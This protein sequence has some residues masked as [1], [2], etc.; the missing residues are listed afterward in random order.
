MEMD[1]D[2]QPTKR[3]QSH[4]RQLPVDD[5][6]PFDFDQYVASY[7]GRTLIDRLLFLIPQCPSLAVQA[8]QVAAHHIKYM[9]DVSLVS[10]LLNAYDAATNNA[11]PDAPLPPFS[12]VA[13][14]DQTWIE[15]TNRRNMDERAKLEVELKTYSSNMIKESIRV[16]GILV[17]R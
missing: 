7:S 3:Q 5:D 9:R 4:I 16:S 15:E 17:H 10:M 6:H 1:I 13:H 8:T 12:E 14:I 11:P 2:E